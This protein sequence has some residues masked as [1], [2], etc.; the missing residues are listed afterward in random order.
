MNFTGLV[1]VNL[2]LAEKC[3]EYRELFMLLPNFPPSLLLFG[4][5][6]IFFSYI[7]GF[8]VLYGILLTTL[9]YLSVDLIVMFPKE[10]SDC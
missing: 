5:N 6:K 10:P 8:L 3:E 4:V 1:V 2:E 9:L 7:V